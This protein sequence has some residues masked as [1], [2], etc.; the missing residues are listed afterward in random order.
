MHVGGEGKE[1]EGEQGRKGE[2]STSQHVV[3]LQAAGLRRPQ[4]M[5]N[6]SARSV[7]LHH[8]GVS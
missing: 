6:T 8:K 7:P 2:L 3:G 4:G 5:T 1:R